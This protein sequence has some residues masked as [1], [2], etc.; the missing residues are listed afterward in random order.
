[1][2]VCVSAYFYYCKLGFA[3]DRQA[4]FHEGQQQRRDRERVEGQRRQALRTAGVDDDEQY[5]PACI[6]G[7]PRMATGSLRCQS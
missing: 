4:A 1:M 6:A 2:R 3:P 5:M 7:M